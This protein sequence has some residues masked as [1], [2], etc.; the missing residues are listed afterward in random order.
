MSH[1]SCYVIHSHTFN[2]TNTFIFSNYIIIDCIV[3]LNPNLRIRYYLGGRY[4]G[5]DVVGEA[6]VTLGHPAA[7][8]SPRRI[9]FP[10]ERCRGDPKGRLSGFHE[11]NREHIKVLYYAVSFYLYVK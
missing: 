4:S 3:Q 10:V 2:K 6:V 11:K 8:V 5:C 9:L 7:A 1:H